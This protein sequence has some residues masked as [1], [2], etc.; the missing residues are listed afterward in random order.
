MREGIQGKKTTR[1]KVEKTNGLRDSRRLTDKE[2]KNRHFLSVLFSLIPLRHRF[3][4]LSLTRC[5]WSVCL[6]HQQP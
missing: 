6:K 3:F 1:R 4:P 2:E 5:D